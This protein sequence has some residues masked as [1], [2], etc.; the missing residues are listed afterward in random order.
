ME[1]MIE[2]RFGIGVVGFCI[3]PHEVTCWC[4][5]LIFLVDDQSILFRHDTVAL[6]NRQGI[7]NLLSSQ[8]RKN[9]EDKE[10]QNC[11]T[12]NHFFRSIEFNTPANITNLHREIMI[13][14]TVF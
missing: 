8:S 4:Q 9:A 1:M 13:V 12:V 6:F 11:Y 2:D 7:L 10:N 3:G 14:L 5:T